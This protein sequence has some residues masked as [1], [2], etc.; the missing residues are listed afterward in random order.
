MKNNSDHDLLDAYLSGDVPAFT[1]LVR[2]H[3]GQLL[4]FL[5]KMCNDRQKAEDLLQ[6][7]FRKVHENAGKIKRDSKFKS[8][9][10][11]VASNM[12]IDSIR[13]QTRQPRT[14]SIDTPVTD[15]QS[16]EFGLSA[17]S[18]IDQE[19]GPFQVAEISEKRVQIKN[20]LAKLPDKQRT[21][22]ILSYYQGLSYK[23]IAEVHDCSLGTVKTHMFRALKRLAEIL[24]DAREVLE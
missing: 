6:E 15:N 14:M 9:L 20:A 7:T 2:R 23:E 4:G 1:E 10:F 17:D 12:A 8:W 3:S 16:V 24:P 18:L 22:L 11:T 21:T 19:P 5:M 13:K